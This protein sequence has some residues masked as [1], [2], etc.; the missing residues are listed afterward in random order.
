MGDDSFKKFEEVNKN[1]DQKV[2]IM[3]GLSKEELNLLMKL[4][5]ENFSNYKDFIFAT[6]TENSIKWKLKDL[7]GELGKEHEYFKDKKK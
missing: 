5:K 6:T 7:I 1:S 2:I 4:M 3:H